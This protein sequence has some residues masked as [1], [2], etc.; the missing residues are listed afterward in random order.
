[1]FAT[2]IEISGTRLRN[3]SGAEAEW[4]EKLL[5]RR[6]EIISAAMMLQRSSALIAYPKTNR[7][8]CWVGRILT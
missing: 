1:M 7:G 4:T 6:Y 5:M 2:A 8:P 3:R